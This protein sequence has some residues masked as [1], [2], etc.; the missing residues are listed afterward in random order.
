MGLDR[1]VR[2]IPEADWKKLRAVRDRVIDRCYAKALADLKADVETASLTEDPYEAYAAVWK[3]MKEREKG[4]GDLFNDW[5]RS[6]VLMTIMGWARLGLL[7]EDEFESLSDETKT[8][9][10]ALVDVRF[11]KE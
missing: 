3:R 5:R 8:T 1:A 7:T 10:R 9:V 2:T 6:T 4:F 11:P